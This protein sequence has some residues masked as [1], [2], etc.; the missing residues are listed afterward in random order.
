MVGEICINV[1]SILMNG[2]GTSG[3]AY[4]Q[5]PFDRSSSFA[6]GLAQLRGATDNEQRFF[7]VILGV[8][9]TEKRNHVRRDV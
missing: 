1:F 7:C 6:L 9:H 4:P 5:R 3:V 8:T 2:P